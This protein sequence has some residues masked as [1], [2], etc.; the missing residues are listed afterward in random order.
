MVKDSLFELRCAKGGVTQVEGNTYSFLTAQSS[1]RQKLYACFIGLLIVA[2]VCITLL[3]TNTQMPVIKPFLLAHTAVI[4]FVEWMTAYLLWNQYRITCSVAHLCLSMTYFYSGL[5]VI[6]YILTFPGIFSEAGLLGAG[7]QT[8]AYLWI[9]WHAGFPL[10]LMLFYFINRYESRVAF[11]K[12]TIKM[13]PLFMVCIVMCI[14][15]FECILTIRYHNL[16]P[17][18][19]HSGGQ[20]GLST[21]TIGLG[22]SL[23]IGSI[24]LLFMKEK[25]K[26]LLHVLLLLALVSFLAD[27]LLSIT[28]TAR[29]TVGW[30]AARIVSLFSSSVVLAAFIL[31]LN[32]L[33]VRLG[34]AHKQLAETN[35]AL[36]Q[37]LAAINR[38]KWEIAQSEEKYRL[39]VDHIH[40]AVFLMGGDRE[41]LYVNPSWL[42]LTGYTGD[43]SRG[44]DLLEFIHL[45]E[46]EEMKSALHS[47]I[48]ESKDYVIHEMRCIHKQGHVVW[49]E[50]FA[51]GVRDEDGVVREIH[52]TI[53]DVTEQ[54]GR[55]EIQRNRVLGELAVAICHEVRN[56]LTATK[57]FLQLLKEETAGENVYINISMEELNKA[58]QVLSDYLQFS[59]PSIQQMEQIYLGELLVSCINI[60]EPY[61]LSHSV[62][63][64]YF[65]QPQSYTYADREMLSQAAMH[66]M[67]N[68]I[69]AMQFGGTLTVRAYSREQRAVIEIHD[70]GKGMTG[71][72]ISRLGEPFYTLKEKGTGLSM[73]MTYQFI[74]A[75]QGEIVVDSK[76][77]VG[78][79]VSILLPL[80][81]SHAI[82]V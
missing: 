58:E 65:L 77:G 49:T 5:I 39:V 29:Y 63:I 67:K 13:L 71:E 69:E 51:K 35:E 43:E 10:G 79:K 54:R 9:F 31:E 32:Q 8:A 21:N 46:R 28:G 34:K 59:R 61:A 20:Y 73:M 53:R 72:Q 75:M 52:G 14:V 81:E 82:G 44:L 74:Y 33:Y 7:S 47:L 48:Y 38:Q 62:Q 11:S 68:G 16:F 15:I 78:T 23:F 30:Y 57:G 76:V 70:M 66:V 42:T 4:V 56:P 60:I 36:E 3:F 22:V 12:R 80:K 27:V 17:S 6:P 41:L 18:V 1:S 40:E 37:Q 45:D 24:I 55:F 19:V 2:I 64:S 50:L 26:P 25:K